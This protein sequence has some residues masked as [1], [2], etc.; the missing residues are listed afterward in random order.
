MV[1]TQRIKICL[2]LL[3]FLRFEIYYIG[4]GHPIAYK[5][6][7]SIILEKNFKEICVKAGCG[8]IGEKMSSKTVR[9]QHL[10]SLIAIGVDSANRR[11]SSV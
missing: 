11:L 3:K 2:F 10:S 5:T 6:K 8:E 4:F 9:S 7:L 1:L